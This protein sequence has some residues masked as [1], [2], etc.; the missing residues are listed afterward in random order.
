MEFFG[1]LTE[2]RG[3]IG[4]RSAELEAQN[5]IGIVG[6][7]DFIGRAGGTSLPSRGFEKV[8]Q[9][10]FAAPAARTFPHFTVEFVPAVFDELQSGLQPNGARNIPHQF[11][12]LFDLL[13]RP[14]DFFEPRFDAEVAVDPFLHHEVDGKLHAVDILGA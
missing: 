7:G 6:I 10:D 3:H 4:E 8:G 1:A 9:V 11:Q 12:F 5:L 13:Q 2:G 14:F